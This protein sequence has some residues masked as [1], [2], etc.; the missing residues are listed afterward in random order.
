MDELRRD[1]GSVGAVPVVVHLIEV[2]LD[3]YFLALLVADGTLATAFVEVGEDL[4]PCGFVGG[5]VTD[6]ADGAREQ[7]CDDFGVRVG[8]IPPAG[9]VGDAV[10]VGGFGIMSPGDAAGLDAEGGPHG[11]VGRVD[12]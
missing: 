8:V 1:V 6:R 10:P 2:Q 4:V 3:D 11:R 5:G 9:G 12:G 7:L